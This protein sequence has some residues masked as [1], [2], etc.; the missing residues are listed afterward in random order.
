MPMSAT[1]P[2][3]ISAPAMRAMSEVVRERP[4]AAIRLSGGMV[5]PTSTARIAWSEGRIR[6][7]R[8]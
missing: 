3:P 5:W 2:A 4:S 8:P 6:P 1:P 7:A